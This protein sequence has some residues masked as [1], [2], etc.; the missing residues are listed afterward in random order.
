MEQTLQAVSIIKLSKSYGTLKSSN[1]V[2]A[3]KEI[4]LEIGFGE[5]F[6]IIGP[7]GAGKT[8]L[9]RILTSLLIPTLGQATVLGLDI[10]KDFKLL[11]EKIGYM[12]GKFSLYG[13][14]TV[15]ENLSFFASIFKANIKENYYLI[16]DIFKDIAPF[17]KRKAQDLSGGMKQKLALSCALVHKPEILFLDEPTTGVDPV[18]RK[19]FWQML[20]RL[21]EQGITIVVSTSYMD[22]ALLCDRIALLN[23]GLILSYDTPKGMIS[24][25]E[26]NLL[27]VDGE[28]M[29]ELLKMLR[30]IPIVKRAYSFGAQHHITIDREVIKE[31]RGKI[32]KRGSIIKSVTQQL[33]QMGATSF[34]IR[35]IEPTIEDCY[36]ELSSSK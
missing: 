9:F 10:V 5:M 6:G 8:T 21:K 35:E 23:E 15:D 33:Q 26:N 31:Y 20:K 25:F 32:E 14:L 16:E 28:N 12:P 22:E 30:K 3:L 34:N 1:R 36:L 27:A 11:R 7:D 17:G 19:E 2:E 4:S 13:D 24:S 18:S 29:P